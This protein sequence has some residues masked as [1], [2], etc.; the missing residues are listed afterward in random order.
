VTQKQYKAVM[1]KN[2]SYFC[3]DGQGSGTVANLNTDD[4]PV[5]NVSWD[6]AQEF[7]KKLNAL[8]AE[9][10]LGRKYRL[11]TEA[12]WEYGCRAGADVK[13]PFTFKKPS[14]SASSKQANF[15]GNS[16]F[17][18]AERGPTLNRPCKVG[19]Y[20]P[21]PFGLYDMHGNILEWCEDWF[22]ETT[23][24]EKD[25]KDPKGPNNGQYRMLKGGAFN[26]DALYCRSGY[27]NYT[28]PN[29]RANSFGFRVACVVRQD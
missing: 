25:R 9:K 7:I 20:E 3:K 23:F 2:P 10:N 11:P 14:D 15:N 5:E 13:E 8:A 16:P 24:S 21:N 27:R 1:D 18:G 22:G 28:S 6:D 29:Q 12:E 17:G 4:F 19:S 26:Y